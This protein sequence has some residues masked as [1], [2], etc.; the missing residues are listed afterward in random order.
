MEHTK[1]EWTD[2]LMKV[3]ACTD[4]AGTCLLFQTSWI[5][6]KERVAEK[7]VKYFSFLFCYYV[8][9]HLNEQKTLGT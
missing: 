4:V 1:K 2:K 5:M 6:S 7:K 3:A 8:F 9:I